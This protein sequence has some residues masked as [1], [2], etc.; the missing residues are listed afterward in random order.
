[1]A[2]ELHGARN[3]PIVAIDRMSPMQWT[4]VIDSLADF[5]AKALEWGA[6]PD[7]VDGMA[8]ISAEAAHLRP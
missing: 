8:S 7:L 6:L 4:L 3:S 2:R 5:E 1:M